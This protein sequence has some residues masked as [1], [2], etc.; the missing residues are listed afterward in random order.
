MTLHG[1]KTQKTTNPVQHW[2]R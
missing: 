2:Y 1:A